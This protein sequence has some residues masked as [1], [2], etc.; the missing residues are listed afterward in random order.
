MY[1]MGGKG[2]LVR[3]LLEAVARNSL[4]ILQNGFSPVVWVKAWGE[5]MDEYIQGQSEDH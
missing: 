2:R 1:C 3:R 5:I 4:V